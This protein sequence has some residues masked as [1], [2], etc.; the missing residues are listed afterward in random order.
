MEN[1]SVTKTPSSNFSQ[2]LLEHGFI[3]EDRFEKMIQKLAAKYGGKGDQASPQEVTDLVLA[4]KILDEEDVA[5]AR[6]A[7]LNLPYV[8]LRNVNISQQVLAIIPEES[9][10]FYRMIPYELKGTDL[11]VALEDPSHIQALEALEFL[12]QKANYQI[13]IYLGSHSSIG[14]AL[15]GSKNLSV[16]VGAALEDIQKTEEVEQAANYDVRD[17]LKK[18]ADEAAAEDAPIIK[19][20]DV[21]LSNAIEASA[22][23][24]HIEPSENDVRVRYRIDG[25]LHTSLRLPRNVLNAIVSRIKILSNLKIEEQRLPQDGRFHAEF[26]SN[27]VDLRVSTL[28][29]MHGEKIVMR[30]LD[31]T[32]SVPTLDQLGLR[33]KGLEWVMENIKKTHGVFLITGPTG[34][35]KSTTLYSILSLRNSS[36]VNIV[37]LEDPV[38][39][40]MEGVNQSQINPDIG[41]TF[42]S[43]LRS[44]LRQDPN[45]V[46]VGEIRDE[47]TA[48]LAI[49]AALTGHLVFSTLHT[50]NAVGA[51]PRLANMWIEQFLLSASL[52]LMMA[53]RLV[54]KLCE[55][56][57]KPT[58]LTDLVKKEIDIAMK[59]VPK[60][61]LDKIDLKNYKAFEAVGCKECGDIGYKGR[62]GI[63]EVMP[64]M[65]EFQEILFAKKPAHEIYELTVKYGMITMKQD[66]IVKVL[67]GETTMD[68]IIRVTTE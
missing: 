25:I 51:I 20:V 6:A 56:C 13:H 34:S 68:E 19:I 64:M 36:D 55:T 35:G 39:Y 23:D 26:G 49:H 60:D 4:Q 41:L 22:S 52:N 1:K 2:F 48:E 31:K 61:Y 15:K 57:K 32:T 30:I 40:F 47:E 58:T 17:E 59:T 21:I 43:G 44:I 63:F 37:T 24:I 66:G 42:A 67:R 10:T 16:V 29:L 8:D 3:N 27:S 33:G 12:G 54:R 50:N 45:I 11:K 46:M 38:E 7:F 9:R 65:N 62:M 5:K 53:Q 18:T 28:P 14:T